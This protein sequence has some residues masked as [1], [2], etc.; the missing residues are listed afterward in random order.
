MAL[1][2]PAHAPAAAA[3]LSAAAAR[4][5]TAGELAAH[6]GGRLVGHAGA[7]ASNLQSID[8]ADAGSLTF[9]RADKF[10][11]AWASSAAA[12]ALVAEGV[13]VPGHDPDRR[14]LI[15]VREPDVAMVRA[16]DMLRPPP[17]A[18]A[19][20]VHPL[21]FV[22]ATARVDP[23]ASIGPFSV[24]GPGCSVGAGT[25]LVSHVVLDGGATIGSHCLI[26]PHVSILAGSV[27][28]S[29]CAIHAS[30]VIGAD[31]F[32]YRPD[33]AGLAGESGGL[34]KIPHLG[35]VVVEDHVEIGACACI[36]RARFGSTRIGAGTK[37]DNLVQ[38]AHNCRI[39]RC[40]VI[41]GCTGIA[42]SVTIGDFCQLGGN[43]GIADNVTLGRGVR[44]AA[45]TGVMQDVPDGA[46]VA[47]LPAFPGREY[48]RMIAAL[49][50]LATK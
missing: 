48:L 40:V 6:V 11:R 12:I 36:D 17:E 21:A 27:I 33:P 18:V 5:V 20:G 41:T 23:S 28:G 24:V 2:T 29:R 9:I 26:H 34:I 49:R 16:L 35:N 14:A 43:C 1:A 3:N 8:Q 45:K 44:V 50:K 37:I 47:G 30:A 42:G 22:D 7:R 31:G 25:R 10:A 39:G 38:I 19:P 15:F 46:T 4:S 32:G 13:D